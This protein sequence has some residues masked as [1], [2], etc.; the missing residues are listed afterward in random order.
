[1]SWKREKELSARIPSPEA[2]VKR[3]IHALESRRPRARYLVAREAYL[4]VIL[5]RILPDSLIDFLIR[6]HMKKHRNK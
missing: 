5:K 4:F 6:Q 2:V 1:M 3:I